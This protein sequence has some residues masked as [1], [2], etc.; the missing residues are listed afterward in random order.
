MN[1]DIDLT[2]V[3]EELAHGKKIGAIRELRHV[4]TWGLKEAKEYVEAMPE[5]LAHQLEMERE[6]SE[7]RAN[8][9]AWTRDLE[10]KLAAVPP[11]NQDIMDRLD[12]IEQMLNE[13]LTELRSA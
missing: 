6:R 9:R 3:R 11:S 1:T 10:T 13:V 12:N 7:D 4:T 2:K 8:E 5:H